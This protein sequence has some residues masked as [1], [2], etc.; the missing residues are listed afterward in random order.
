MNGRSSATVLDLEPKQSEFQSEVMAGLA[1][2]PQTLPCKYFYDKTGAELFQ[3]ICE[4][5][6]YYITRTELK[7]L[8]ASGREMASH[9]GPEVELIGLGTGAGTKTKILLEQ[10]TNPAVYIPVDISSGQLAQSS[11][12]FHHLFPSLEIL[13]VCADYLQP[14]RLPSPKRRAA[15]KVVY[16]PGSTIGNFEPTAA[17]D[18]LSRIADLCGPGGGLLIGVDLQKDAEIL[19][20]AYNDTRGVTAKFNLNLLA[21]INR[22]LNGDFQ[23][24]NWRHRAVYNTGA[25]RIEMN[26]ISQRDQAVHIGGRR[27]IFEAGEKVVTEFSYKHTPD[28]FAELGRK[29]G[30][31]F[32]ELWTD[33]EKLFGVFFFRRPR[34]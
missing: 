4:L 13:P 14:F 2:S 34:S 16:F 28:G 6:E 29:A 5:P 7:I 24:Q 10:L 9:L 18:F 11:T 33:E 20:A 19:E 32:D 12:L 8:Q 26:L 17:L 27:F 22:E 15:R 23:L 1:T 30:F 21:R 31:E 3:K 25:G